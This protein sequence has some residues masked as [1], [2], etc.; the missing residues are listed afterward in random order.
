MVFSEFFILWLSLNKGLSLYFSYLFT[1]TLSVLYFDRIYTLQV[2]ICSIVVYIVSIILRGII[3]DTTIFY[4][5]ADMSKARISWIC[6][7]GIGGGVEILIYS[8]FAIYLAGTIRRIL[9]SLYTNRKSVIDIQNKL[10]LSFANMVEAK[11][12]LTGEH[13]K[14]TSEYVKLLCTKLMEKGIYSEYVTPHTQEIMVRATP[15]HDLGK[16]SIPD[17]ILNKA[18]QLTYEE[19]EIIKT[20]PTEGAEF[21]ITKLGSLDDQEFIQVAHDM[22]LYHH[23]HMDGSGYPRG[24]KGDDIPICARIMAVADVLDAL[25]SKRS[26]KEAFPLERAFSILKEMSGTSL[27]PFIVGVLLSCKREV[28]IIRANGSLE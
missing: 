13:V 11:D 24:I 17:K 16:I 9:E 19:F 15:F 27:D 22:A 18:G 10:I 21:I 8:I 23:E 26:Y 1:I 7:Y 25:L 5:V 20:H 14:R 28:E 6:T 2:S 12:H 3:A 4:R